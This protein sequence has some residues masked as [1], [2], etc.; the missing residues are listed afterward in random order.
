MNQLFVMFAHQSYRKDTVNKNH[1]FV[2]FGHPSYKKDKKESFF[3]KYNLQ[4]TWA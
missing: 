3:F 2:M 4:P 1:L